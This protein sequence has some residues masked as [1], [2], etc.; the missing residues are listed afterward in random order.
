MLKII[1]WLEEHNL[2]YA[3]KNIASIERKLSFQLNDNG[4][5]KT[6]NIIIIYDIEAEAYGF[7]CSFMRPE[8]D[9]IFFGD[10]E[11]LISFL[12]KFCF[13]CWGVK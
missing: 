10:E 6:T 12:D 13:I 4:T 3:M 2:E 5:N 11:E 9:D 8:E 1:E 7:W